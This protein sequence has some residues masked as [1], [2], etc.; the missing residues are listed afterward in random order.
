EID[1]QIKALTASEKIVQST[2]GWDE[3][4]GKT[5]LQRVKEFAEDYRY[6]P[7]PDIPPLQLTPEWV[8]ERRAELPE[9][10]DERRAR[11]LAEYG[12]SPYDAETLTAERGRADYYERAVASARATGITPK[13]VANWMTG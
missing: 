11:F 2:R 7:E 5:V 13:D 3:A 12:L 10:P 9:L 6:F 8:E 1:R 4:Q